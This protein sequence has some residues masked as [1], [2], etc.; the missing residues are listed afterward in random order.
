[1]KETYRHEF[2]P[3]QKAIS[4]LTGMW[5]INKDS[6]DFTWGYFAP[7]FGF[8]FLINRGGYFNSYYSI[9][10]C[11]IWGALNIKLPFKTKLPEGCSLPRYG[12]TLYENSIMF[13]TGGKYDKDWGQVT[14]GGCHVWYI[15]FFSYKFEGHWIKDKNNQWVLMDNK[16]A[17]INSKS[18]WD[19]RQED[20]LLYES[21]FEYE[22]NSGE[23]QHRIAKYTHE[24]RQWGRKWFPF[25][26][27]THEVID[28]NF[29]DEV[30]ERSG[31]WKG[32]TVGCTYEIKPSET[33][34]HCFSRMIVERTFD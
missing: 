2:T 34:E 30:G 22:L 9:N 24:K 19:F 4:K 28:V 27:M 1:M 20:A 11:F 13:Y 31:S 10:F 25:L 21:D 3:V 17:K 7:R 26:K 33:P 16:L 15:P 6:I 5:R 8:E 18:A 32:G 12:F 29:N 14:F 23:I